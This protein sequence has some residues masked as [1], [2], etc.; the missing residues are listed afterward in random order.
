MTRESG[1]TDHELVALEAVSGLQDVHEALLEM[2]A[3]QERPSISDVTFER[4]GQIA[5]LR[6]ANTRFADELERLTAALQS[7]R[8]ASN[9]AAG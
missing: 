6:L 1:D 7:L 8:A 4:R 5:M 9:Q 3:L 2:Q